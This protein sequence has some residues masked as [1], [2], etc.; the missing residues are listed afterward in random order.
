MELHSILSLL[1]DGEFH[2]GSDLGR[3][4]G[5]SRT[6]VWK[7]LGQLEELDL[8]LESVKGRGYRLSRGLDLLDDGEILSHIGSEVAANVDIEVL[9][10]TGS[11][12]SYL[13]GKVPSGKLYDCCFAEYQT[14]GKG[15]RGRKWVSPFAR[16]IYFSMAFDLE[17]GAEALSG[18]SLVIGL[19]VARTLKKK[20]VT[21]IELKWPNDIW[22][23][24]KKIAGIL[25]ELHGEATTAWRV[26]LGLGLN[27]DMT[28]AEAEEIDQPWACLA[29][30]L[31]L[32]RSEVSGIVLSGL[33]K[34]LE[35][36]KTYGFTSFSKE[37]LAYDGLLGK[38]V[39][40]NGGVTTGIARGVDVTGALLLEQEEGLVTI[41]AGEV[42]VRCE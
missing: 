41:N 9:L 26:V 15:R 3:A 19:S 21:G 39:A 1:S 37:W 5:V 25:V 42:S 30:V 36:F 11:T 18:L 6:A 27:V 8:S 17:G 12:N 28:E 32:D 10:R 35:L 33:I 16:N 4:L 22:L 23:Q 38:R 24:G 31:Q 14:Q 20:G 7:T 40:I 29:S 13:L 34:D 2:S